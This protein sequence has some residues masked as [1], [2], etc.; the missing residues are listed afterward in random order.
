MGA[1]SVSAEDHLKIFA[2]NSGLTPRETEFLEALIMTD[3]DVEGIARSFGLTARTVHR[4]ISNIYEKTG[5]DSRY[6]LMRC[7]YESKE[8]ALSN[9][10]GQVIQKA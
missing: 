7:F 1:S 6:A 5:T 3:T 9:D 8:G 2:E 4:H 10:G